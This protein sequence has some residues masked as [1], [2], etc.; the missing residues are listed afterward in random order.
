MNKKIRLTDFVEKVFETPSLEHSEWFGYYNYDTLNYN[1]TKLLC[2]RAEFDGVQP[3]L[4]MNIELGFYDIISGQWNH[5]GF[6]DSWNWQQGAMLQWRQ[7]K[8]QE[9]VIYNKSIGGRLVSIVHN[10]QT[11]KERIID[12]PIYGLTPDGKKSISLD[13]ERSYWCR[14]YHY[15]SVS[16]KAKDGRVYFD[17]GIFEIDLEENKRKRIIS[18]EDIIACDEEAYF[19]EMKH[20]LE[21]IMISPDGSRFCFL[22][23]YSPMDNVYA[24]K[25]RVFIADIDGG[26]LQI[27][28]GGDKYDWSHFGWSNNNNFVIYTYKKSRFP[29]TRGL[30]E[31][32]KSQFSLKEL[33]H[34]IILSSA[35]F[36]PPNF[37]RKINGRE[38][39]YQYYAINQEGKYVLDCEF[40]NKLFEIDGHPSFTADN[41]FLVTDTYPDSKGYQHL[42]I[43]DIIKN[44]G[45]VV[46]DFF[47]YYHK[48]PAS[49]D[50]HPKLCVNNNYIVVDTAYDNRHHMMVLKFNWEKIRKILNESG[51]EWK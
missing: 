24:Y 27:I 12:W 25:T 44:R 28:K 7:G 2:N 29:G 17:D 34:R 5:I 20:W 1:Q 30:I 13:L 4:G 18:I 38:N 39:F 10:I 26:N 51:N 8:F 11:K 42:M 16:N 21:H 50:L 37:R 41:R 43:F 47:A 32:F 48:T 19:S 6:S 46:A 49:C 33:F 15:K 35:R 3:E 14:A 45:V 40:R 36:F 9:E 22:H 31:I 23:R